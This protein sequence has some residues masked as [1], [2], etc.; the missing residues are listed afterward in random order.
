M[1]R[2]KIY[3][4][5]KTAE[6]HSKLEALRCVKRYIAREVYGLIRERGREITQT[7]IESYRD[8][9]RAVSVRQA[10]AACS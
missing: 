4:A 1:K 10:T 7:R 2:A 9:R 8:P 6:G 3:A 5:K